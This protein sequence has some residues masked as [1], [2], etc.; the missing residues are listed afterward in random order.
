MTKPQILLIDD[1]AMFRAG[2]SLVIGSAIPEVRIVEAAT[3]DGALGLPLDAVDLVL[4]DIKL[5][6]VSG[7]DGIAL[8]KR[9][10]PATP[11][12]MLSSLDEPKT[13]RLAITRGAA[14]FMSKAETAEKIVGA[15]TSLLQG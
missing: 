11:I 9:N 4:L 7:L 3:I 2:L 6:G 8:L 12:L 1:H 15:V 14:G 13:E 5:D 10:W